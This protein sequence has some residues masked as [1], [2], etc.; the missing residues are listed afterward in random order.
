MRSH[1]PA[2]IGN[3]GLDGTEVSTG[4][5]DLGVCL[6]LRNPILPGFNPDPSIIFVEGDYFLTTSTFEYFP[7]LPIYHSR[8][9]VNW[10]LIGHVLTRASQLDL[11]TVPPGGGIFAPTLRYW[12]GR[13]YVTVCAVHSRTGGDEE[14]VSSNHK[15]SYRVVRSGRD[16]VTEEHFGRQTDDQAQRLTPEILPY[17]FDVGPE[18]STSGPTTYGTKIAGQ[19]R[20]TTTC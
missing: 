5:T 17:S 11:R 4:A 20:P 6:G 8:D 10:T 19:S 3:G 16:T 2:I 18:G 9:L 13:Y 15:Y 1:S 14:D 12:K 7:G